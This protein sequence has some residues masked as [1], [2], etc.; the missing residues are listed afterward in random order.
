MVIVWSQIRS[1][2]TF[3]LGGRR[4]G[5]GE[6]G[7]A[8]RGLPTKVRVEPCHAMTT[9]LLRPFLCVSNELKS[10]SFSLLIFTP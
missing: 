6:F 9:L 8:V 10:Q 4:G 2:S 7:Q 1:L 5:I 3:F